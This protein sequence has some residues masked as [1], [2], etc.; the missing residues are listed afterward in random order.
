MLPALE[1]ALTWK[2]DKGKFRILRKYLEQIFGPVWSLE[3]LP[4]EASAGSE[5]SEEKQKRVFRL[6]EQDVQKLRGLKS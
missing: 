4:G 3:R 2:R 5:K 6:K 1:S